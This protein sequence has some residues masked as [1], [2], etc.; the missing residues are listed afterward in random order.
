MF[1]DLLSYPAL[2]GVI[3]AGAPVSVVW[4]GRFGIST[5]TMPPSG[6]E[7]IWQLER[8]GLSHVGPAASM[9]A[10]TLFRRWNCAIAQFWG[11]YSSTAR[12]PRAENRREKI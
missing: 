7:R 1:I 11:V 8:P 4:S 5:L 12:N 2:L 9:C 6:V 10:K 3:G